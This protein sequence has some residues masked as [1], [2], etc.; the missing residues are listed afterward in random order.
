LTSETYSIKPH[1][2]LA[3]RHQNEEARSPALLVSWHILFRRPE[4]SSF[5]RSTIS[6]VI[7]TVE[8]G[9]EKTPFT[10]H[11]DLLTACSPYFKA[12]FEGPFREARDKSIPIS[13]VE[14]KTF[15]LFLD[16]LYFRRLPE[17]EGHAND[18]D[19]STCGRARCHR[20]PEDDLNR[21]PSSKTDR[22]RFLPLSKE[23]DDILE[24]TIKN[25]SH[26][27]LHLYVFADRCDV[28]SL[29]Q[30][31]VDQEWKRFRLG[32]WTW[33]WEDIIYALRHL[34]ISTPLCKLLVDE[35]IE[36]W[37][38]IGLVCG[39]EKRLWQKIPSEFLFAVMMGKARVLANDWLERTNSLCKYHEHAQ[40][41]NTTQSCVKKFKA[42]RKR[43]REEL[44][45]ENR[46]VTS[47][48]DS[49]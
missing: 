8:I 24:D 41:D 35:Y 25:E 48:L 22:H 46:L 39:L 1:S 33:R 49:A 29:R 27:L 2:N 21:G 20:W 37:T 10:V 13:D 28:P 15:Q 45:R 17:D 18:D 6:N 7:V 47:D 19:C 31:I 26:N 42:S 12:A 23:D 16:W 34:S 4:H 14:P 3:D 32:K 30:A 36:E 43:K 44:A 11:K 5:C 40:D 9:S 38:G